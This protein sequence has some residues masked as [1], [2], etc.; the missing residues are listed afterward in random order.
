M[1]SAEL[2]KAPPSQATRRRRALLALSSPL[3]VLLALLALQLRRGPA[4]WEVLPALLIGIGLLL[5]SLVRRRQRRGEMLR[6]L[7]AQR[8]LRSGSGDGR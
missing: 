1:L 5:T 4:R 2:V 3:L 7:R 6:S 8:L